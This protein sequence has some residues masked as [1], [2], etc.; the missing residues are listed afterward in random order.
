MPRVM[1]MQVLINEAINGRERSERVRNMLQ[2]AHKAGAQ[3]VIGDGSLDKS[4]TS[5]TPIIITNVKPNDDL[6]KEEIFS[7]ASILIVVNDEDDAV[8]VANDTDYGLNAAV[9]SR[10]ILAAIRIAKKIEAGQVHI[11]TTTEYD[12]A[13]IP[14]GGTKG[15]G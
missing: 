2:S 13:K 3:L 8:R 5:L 1:R 6:F 11:G 10:D 14:I 7:T 9:H 15:S 12:E 4:S